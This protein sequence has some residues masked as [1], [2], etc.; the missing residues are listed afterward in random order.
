MAII[1]VAGVCNVETTPRVDGFPVDYTPVRY[2]FF[3]VQSGPSG[4]GY[5]V[6]AAL[7]TLGDEVRL[8]SSAHDSEGGV[9]KHVQGDATMPTVPGAYL[10]VV[11]PDLPVT[12]MA[13]KAHAL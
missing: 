13:R 5:N 2:P 10:V 8:A 4:V 11:E 7:A 3:G 1:A 6:A 9:G 12:E